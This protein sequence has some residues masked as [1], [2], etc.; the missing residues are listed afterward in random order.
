MKNSTAKLEA[1]NLQK[2]TQ[3]FEKVTYIT[4]FGAC[5]SPVFLPEFCFLCRV[6]F[7]I[8]SAMHVLALLQD[9]QGAPTT[10]R[11]HSRF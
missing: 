4:R 7:T 5:G 11:L 9:S 8:K 1:F 6:Y 3:L 10:P 2:V